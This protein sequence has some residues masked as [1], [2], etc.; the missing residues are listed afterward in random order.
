MICITVTNG[1]RVADSPDQMYGL[2][3]EGHTYYFSMRIVFEKI[4]NPTPLG[5]PTMLAW[6]ESKVYR[7]K[8]ERENSPTQT[9]SGNK[10]V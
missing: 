10:G 9:S 7:V 4:S 5:N 3:R 2:G 8:G 1:T 6:L